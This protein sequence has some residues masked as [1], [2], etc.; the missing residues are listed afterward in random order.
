MNLLEIARQQAVKIVETAY[1]KAV[2]AGA[3]PTGRAA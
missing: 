2:A 3:L 1:E